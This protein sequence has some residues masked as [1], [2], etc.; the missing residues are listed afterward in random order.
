M[1]D[2]EHDD[3]P[4]R[5]RRIRGG[6]IQ[7]VRQCQR[8]GSAIG[9]AVKQAEVTT[10]PADFDDTLQERWASGVRARILQQRDEATEF[11]R[12]E[13]QRYLLTPEWAQKRKAV[14]ERERYVC[15]GCARGRAT[16]V[17]HLTYSNVGDE[18]LFQLVAVC[19]P[20]H[21]KT[22]GVDPGEQR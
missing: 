6:G 7:Y 3:A 5:M 14:L 10:L 13:Y 8:C 17:H 9:N 19:G 1:W 18:L 11:R 2:C 12:E 4:L 16:E 21:R 15:Q 22:H 20:C